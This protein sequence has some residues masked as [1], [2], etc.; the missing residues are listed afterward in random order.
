MPSRSSNPLKVEP[1]PQEDFPKL[2]FEVRKSGGGFGGNNRFGRKS[3]GGSRRG[4]SRGSDRNSFG[5]RESS[6]RK[7]HPFSDAADRPRRFSG[8]KS[9]GNKPGNFRENKKFNSRDSKFKKDY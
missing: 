7:P 4:S 5:A 1:M 3:F 9:F 2:N 8:S 6:G